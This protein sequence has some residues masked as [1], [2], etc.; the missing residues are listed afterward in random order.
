MASPRQPVGQERKDQKKSNHIKSNQTTIRTGGNTSASLEI[1][2]TTRQR[3]TIWVDRSE[4]R[5]RRDFGLANVGWEKNPCW[6][7]ASVDSSGRIRIPDAWNGYLA[8]GQATRAR[9]ISN[10]E[11]ETLSRQLESWVCKRMRNEGFWQAL[12]FAKSGERHRCPTRP[13]PYM[14]SQ[15]SSC[16]SSDIWRITHRPRSLDQWMPPFTLYAEAY[17]EQ[18][19]PVQAAALHIPYI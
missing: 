17:V 9:E 3:C 18:R 15:Q 5:M 4:A 8:E 7:G 1:P 6:R 13:P 16:T 2:V 10:L 11:L 19:R 12:F 14:Y